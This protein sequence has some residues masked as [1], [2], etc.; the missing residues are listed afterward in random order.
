MYGILDVPG[1][2]LSAERATTCVNRW[3]TS[4]LACLVGARRRTADFGLPLARSDTHWRP[5]PTW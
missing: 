3:S 2:S 4:V 1:H 5:R